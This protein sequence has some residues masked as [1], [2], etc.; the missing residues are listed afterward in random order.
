MAVVRRLVFHLDGS[1]R[2]R[3]DTL[4]RHV[5]SLG[6]TISVFRFPSSLLGNPWWDWQQGG[7]WVT[8]GGLG[9]T[10]TSFSGGRFWATI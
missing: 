4:L 2:D 9:A 6:H 3:D 10:P 1:R 8:R 7:R 5:S